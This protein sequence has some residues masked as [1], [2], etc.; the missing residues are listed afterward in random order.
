MKKISLLTSNRRFS[1]T[2]EKKRGMWIC[3]LHEAGR[4]RSKIIKL[5]IIGITLAV[6]LF[7]VPNALALAI[8]GN[9]IG[10][11]QQGPSVGGGNIVSIFAAAA[12]TWENAIH[13]PFELHIDYGWG[14]DPGGYHYL[15]AQ[16]GSPNR[17][18]NGLIYVQPQIYNDGSYATLFMDPTP[19]FNEEFSPEG[20]SI[21]NLGG[22]ALTVGR[23]LSAA[24]AAPAGLWQDLYTI[25]L[26]EIGHSLG[27]SNANTSFISEAVDGQVQIGADLPFGGSVIPL[28]R[29][30]FG[31]TSHLDLQ[32]GNLMSGLS[33]NERRLPSAA[34]ILVNTQLS[35]FS[36]VNLEATQ[37]VPEP[38]TMLLFATGI[39]GLAGII[40]IRR[41]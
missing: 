1:P 22:G 3:H 32:G 30:N 33:F 11:T 27:I 23:F 13:D 4:S 35:G 40:R 41:K 37:V 34:D 2:L 24:D 6:L 21:Q 15:Q 26:H 18:T 38:T 9:F 5:P 31:V 17:E 10:G 16:S 19:T 29:N 7:R 39:A 8:V 12:G 25:F 20:R 14:P 28:A 36:N